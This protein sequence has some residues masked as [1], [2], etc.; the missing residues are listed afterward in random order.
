MGQPCKFYAYAVAEHAGGRG[1]APVAR[2]V[3]LAAAGQRVRAPVALGAAAVDVA[4]GAVL[5]AVGAADAERV[6]AGAVLGL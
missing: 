1:G 5:R 2:A 3:G 4:L 6:A